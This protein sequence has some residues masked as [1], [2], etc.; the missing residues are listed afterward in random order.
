MIGI[1]GAMELEIEKLISDLENK[2]LEKIAFLEFYIGKLYSKEV[3]IVKSNEG[4]VNSAVATQILISNFDISYILNVG[5]AGALDKTLNIYDVAIS[6]NTVEF[7]QDVTALGY[8]KGYTF[9][10]DL[11]YVEAYTKIAEK[12]SKICGKLH[13]DSKIGTIISSDK[14][15]VNEKE[16]VILKNEFNAIAVDMESA[17]I[18]HVAKLNN[19]PFVALRVISDSGDNVEYVKFAN[20]AADNIS[21]VLKKFF[22]EEVI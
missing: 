4:K 20:R 22:K 3:V 6:S 14:F 11:I 9:G 2:K 10:V 15:I 8:K 17:S 18:N 19:I 5:V 13:L 16:K 12:I 1:I 7:D 21:K